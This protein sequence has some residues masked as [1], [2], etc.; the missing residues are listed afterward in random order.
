MK[1][2]TPVEVS[3]ATSHDRPDSTDTIDS[4]LITNPVA[5]AEELVA[6]ASSAG[7]SIEMTNDDRQW[8][9]A[10]CAEVRSRVAAMR[11]RL[12]PLHPAERRAPP[13]PAELH[14]LDRAALIE[15][16]AYLQANDGVSFP[17]MQ[18]SE[19]TDDDL[20]TILACALDLA[21]AGRKRGG[22]S[23][24]GD[25]RSA[26]SSAPGCI[27]TRRRGTSTAWSAS[28][29]GGRRLMPALARALISE[30]CRRSTASRHGSCRAMAKPLLF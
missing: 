2:K 7:D 1:P 10:M 12:T 23:R 11:R 16:L 30:T 15:R 3:S 14:G 26:T 13:V 27:D 4:S 24:S 22:S 21:E 8:V 29:G 9:A 28:N 17:G 20:R 6:V 5:F 25:C 18:V 19:L